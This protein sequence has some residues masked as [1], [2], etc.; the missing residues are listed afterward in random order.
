VNLYTQEFIAEIAPE[1][2]A[3]VWTFSD[4]PEEPGTVPVPMI[5]VLEHA[6]EHQKQSWLLTGTKRVVL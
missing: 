2:Y 5:R 4:D 1:E 3:W 6:V